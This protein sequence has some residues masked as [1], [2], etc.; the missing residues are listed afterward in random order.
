MAEQPVTI[1]EVD[2]EAISVKQNDVQN[3]VVI[4]QQVLRK[5]LDALQTLGTFGYEGS[6]AIWVNGGYPLVKKACDQLTNN[7]NQLNWVVGKADRTGW[8]VL[9]SPK[10]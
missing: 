4:R 2:A 6:V 1:A 9:V 8:E 10:V 7:S 3:L 5:T